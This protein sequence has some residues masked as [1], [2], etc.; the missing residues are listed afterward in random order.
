PS[1]LRHCE[2][3]QDHLPGN[4]VYIPAQKRSRKAEVEALRA[5]AK[6]L[7]AIIATWGTSDDKLLEEFVAKVRKTQFLASAGAIRP[8]QISPQPNRYWVRLWV[9]ARSA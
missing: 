9:G 1:L 2:P 5:A 3:Y 7:D 6:D 8:C 4:T